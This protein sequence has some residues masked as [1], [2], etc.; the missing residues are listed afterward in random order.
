MEPDFENKKIKKLY[1]LQKRKDSQVAPHFDK[2]WQAAL[3]EK[4][5]TKSFT[6]YKVIAAVAIIALPIL[7]F[8][9]FRENKNEYNSNNMIEAPTDRLLDQSFDNQFIWNWKSPTDK[10]LETSLFI[11]N[12][13]EIKENS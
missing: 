9:V 4:N 10:L 6:Y 3:E 7:Y 12:I 13:T 11:T 8:I 2:L 1:D 5:N